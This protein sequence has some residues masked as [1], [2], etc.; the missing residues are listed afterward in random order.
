VGPCE[1]L[2]LLCSDDLVFMSLI[3]LTASLPISL[4]SLFRTVTLLTNT[5]RSL[6]FTKKIPVNS[7]CIRN[8]FE[9]FKLSRP[10]CY[11]ITNFTEILFMLTDWYSGLSFKYFLHF[12]MHFFTLESLRRTII[13]RG[14]NARPCSPTLTGFLNLF[15]HF[16]IGILFYNYALW[17]Q[18]SCKNS[19][20]HTKNTFVS[21]SMLNLSC[22][23]SHLSYQHKKKTHFVKDHARNI[24]TKF[25]IKCFF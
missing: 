20:Q 4:A 19:D 9:F 15:F 10:V 11:A 17:W 5:T 23:G 1:D 7:P 3:T 6:T 8:Q 13:W 24:P 12:S 2:G 16:P 14:G 25:A 22:V 18:P 21:D